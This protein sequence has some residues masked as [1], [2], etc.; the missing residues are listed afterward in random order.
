MHFAKKP[1]FEFNFVAIVC[2]TCL[3]LALNLYNNDSHWK[4]IGWWKVYSFMVRDV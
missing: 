1:D 3:H 2:K 4:W